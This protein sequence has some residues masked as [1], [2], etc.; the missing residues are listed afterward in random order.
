MTATPLRD[1]IAMPSDEQY[2]IRQCNCD[3]RHFRAVE[4]S[5]GEDSA[6]FVG[7]VVLIARQSSPVYSAECDSLTGNC[8]PLGLTTLPLSCEPASHSERL[9]GAPLDA[10][11]RMRTVKRRDAS[12]AGF[13]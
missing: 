6:V 3:M 12:R 10:H 5:N 7:R 9:S 8:A 11:E 13:L 1:Q 4:A 2:A